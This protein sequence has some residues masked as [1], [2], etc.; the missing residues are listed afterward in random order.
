MP[1]APYLNVKVIYIH[2]VSVIIDS[3]YFRVKSMPNGSGLVKQ[4][5]SIYHQNKNMAQTKP[6]RYAKTPYQKVPTM[7]Y[8]A[9]MP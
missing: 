5:A 3:E 6:Q 1:L 4:R 7:L 8:S 9:F 2:V